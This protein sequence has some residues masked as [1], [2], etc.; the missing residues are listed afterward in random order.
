MPVYRHTV[1]GG[2]EELS[3]DYVSAFPS[4]TFEKIA[5]EGPNEKR[6]R[7]LLEAIENKVDVEEDDEV[8][9]APKAAEKK[10]K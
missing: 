2:E 6:E 8:T 3:E 1:T 4:T 5:D 7:E 10:G 9:P